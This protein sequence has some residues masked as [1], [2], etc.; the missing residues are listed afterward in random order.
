MLL[1]L[2]G[3]AGSGKDTVASYLIDN[4]GF[5]KVAF[6]DAIKDILSAIYGWDR[7]TLEGLTSEDRDFREKEDTWWSKELGI[8]CTPR[9]QM[10]IWGTEIGRKRVHP[11]LWILCVKR[12]VERLL[13][14]GKHVVITDCR[15]MNECDLVK[16]LGGSLVR[17]HR[18]Y[19]E[20]YPVALHTPEEMSSLYP[21]IHV[22]E[23]S[24]IH[25]EVDHIFSNT[26]SIS[27]LHEQVYIFL[28]QNVIS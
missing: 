12:K 10:Q 9:N 1:G 20:W 8:S 18:N 4:H 27:S 19:P 7:Q 25:V 3:F 24:A 23:Y 2:C 13:E 26:E 6:A 16:Q 22:S 11:D 15:F 5:S 21:E 28:K 17:V 14:E